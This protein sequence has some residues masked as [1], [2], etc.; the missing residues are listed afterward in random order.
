MAGGYLYCL[1]HSCCGRAAIRSGALPLLPV[2]LMRLPL[3]LL[4]L[5]TAAA[6]QPPP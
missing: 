6:W 1:R 2:L 4:L 5:Q 3:P